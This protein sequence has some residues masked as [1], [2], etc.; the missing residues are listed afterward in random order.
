VL[1][2]KRSRVKPGVDRVVLLLVTEGTGP[3]T[4]K[5]GRSCTALR[6]SLLL[7]DE[8]LLGVSEDDGTV[9]LVVNAAAE[10]GP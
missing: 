6:A 9:S 5:C 10:P 4:V 3:E 7:D 8:A 1:E 2:S